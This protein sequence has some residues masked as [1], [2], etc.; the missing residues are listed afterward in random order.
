[1]FKRIRDLREDH[2]IK[3]V[4][5]ASE[6]NISQPQ[7]QRYESGTRDI[8]IHIIISLAQYYNV[9]VDYLLGLTDSKVAS[10]PALTASEKKALSYFSRLNTENKDIILG[11]MVKLRREQDADKNRKKDIG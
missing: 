4:V 7:Y 3:Q 2:D 5:L 9:S 10:D 11:E 8:P 6:L 1:M